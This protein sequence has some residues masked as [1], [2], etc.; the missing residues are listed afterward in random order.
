MNVQ[1]LIIDP[2]NDFCNPTGSLYVPGAHES[3]QRLALMINRIGSK[4]DD[5]HITLD[6]H[7]Q[8]DIAHPAFWLESATN[9][10][11]AP[12]TIISV[13]DLAKGKFRTYH[14]GLQAYAADYVAKLANNNRYP[15]C[16]WPVHCDIGSVGAA[17]HEDV[18]N[19]VRDWELANFAIANKVTKG[20]NYLTEHYSAVQADVPDANDPGTMLNID[21]IKMLQ[22][23]DV[24]AIA[25]QA[26]SHCVA[27]TIT[28]IANAFGDDNLVKKFTLL[29]DCT[30]NVPGFDFLGDGFI[31]DMTKR[32]M[33]LSDSVAFFK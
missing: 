15:L 24:I 19:A 3:C 20:S 2:Q 13:D 5:I 14:P 28:D 30:D 7:H 16:I 31:N 29:R 32:G 11:P 8:I 22:E 18:Y 23:A 17:M 25:G 4:L 27:N 21:L 6:S 10:P 33:T 9:A 1:L 12:F 26:L